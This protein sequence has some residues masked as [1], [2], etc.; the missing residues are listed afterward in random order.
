MNDSKESDCRNC[1]H[2]FTGCSKC[3]GHSASQTR[4]VLNRS[5]RTS[6]S[7]TDT[8]R[9]A[10]ISSPT[11]A[12]TT[13]MTSTF[14]SSSPCRQ[15]QVQLRNCCAVPLLTPARPLSE[16]LTAEE[17][18]IPARRKREDA[19]E[20]AACS[21]QR[22]YILKCSSPTQGTIRS[23]RLRLEIRLAARAFFQQCFRT[24]C[25]SRK[26]GT[27]RK[28]H[29]KNQRAVP[30]SL[31][32]TAEMQEGQDEKH[33]GHGQNHDKST[34]ARLPLA[35]PASLGRNG[36]AAAPSKTRAMPSGW[37]S[38]RILAIAYFAQWHQHKIGEIMREKTNFS[39]RRGA[40][41]CR[42]VRLITASTL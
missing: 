4:G 13:I 25:S 8:Q 11:T 41:I 9:H 33:V 40:T 29:E 21:E 10:R 34:T 3:G 2:K 5:F 15:P 37:S 7:L 28:Q 6:S 19:R 32:R 27:Q 18:P 42:M 36:A 22:D 20:N 24:G 35:I 23:A 12:T 16:A 17:P 31:G 26:P 30:F 14:G 39:L 38:L 1:T